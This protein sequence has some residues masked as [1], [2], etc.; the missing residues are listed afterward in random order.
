MVRFS[1][2]VKIGVLHGF[3][4]VFSSEDLINGK[5]PAFILIR[6]K[7][8]TWYFTYILL[9]R[10][11]LTM[12]NIA[13]VRLPLIIRLCV[14]LWLTVFSRMH[15]YVHIHP[16]VFK[17]RWIFERWHYLVFQWHRTVR[18][19]YQIHSGWKP[20]ICNTRK[21]PAPFL[22]WK[23]N[24]TNRNYFCRF[25]STAGSLVQSVQRRSMLTM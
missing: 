12:Q 14:Y 6:G 9:S 5:I 20:D 25:L 18:W 10:L 15:I 24:N 21:T 2:V 3:R 11:L 22:W 19:N 13:A 8:F 17:N 23:K 7:T 1:E 4:V 16:H